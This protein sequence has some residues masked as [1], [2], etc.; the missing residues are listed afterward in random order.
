MDVIW[1]MGAATVAQVVDGLLP[2][3]LAYSTVLTT[4]RTL[5]NKGYLKHEEDGRTYV[6]IPMIGQKNAANLEVSHLIFAFF[7]NSPRALVESLLHD[8]RLTTDDIVRIKQV[9]AQRRR[10]LK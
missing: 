2:P 7:G 5:E 6:Y 10:A 1:R 8:V 4:V 9:L 3:R